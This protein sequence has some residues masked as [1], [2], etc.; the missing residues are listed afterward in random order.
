MKL[1]KNIGYRICRK[2]PLANHFIDFIYL[3]TKFYLFPETLLG[4]HGI[5]FRNVLSTDDRFD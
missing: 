5:E 4:I 2:L 1:E 3:A